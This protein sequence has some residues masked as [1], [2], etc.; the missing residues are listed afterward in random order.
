MRKVIIFVVMLALSLTGCG[1]EA[2]VET[3]PE[4]V[5]STVSAEDCFLCG[6]GAEEPF[7][8]GQNN[9]G[10]INLNTFEV[11]PIEINHYDSHGALIE[12][13]TGCLTSQ[14]I[15]NDDNA[16]CAH[17]YVDADRGHASGSITFNE[18]DTLNVEKMATFLCQDCLDAV[19]L[20]I[21]E[22]G[23]GAGVLNFSTREIR[24]FETCFGGFGLW[25]Y[26]IDLDWKEDKD[27]GSQEVSISVLYC[28][29]RY[30]DE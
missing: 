17:V 15:Y 16:L 30:E 27:G 9:V 14:G 19:L 7:Y 12:E 3:E 10:I 6:N 20:E 29:L 24:P 13:N 5:I 18:D 28:P 8:W 26:Y 1:I 11:M 25:D 23:L 22:K 21:H 4:D 2:S